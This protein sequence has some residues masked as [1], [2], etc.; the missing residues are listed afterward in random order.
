MSLN[1][2]ARAALMFLILYTIL[3]AFLL[4]GYFTRRLR[5]RSRYTVILFHVTIRLASQ[6]TGFAFG[7]VGY[8][9]TSLLIAYFILGAE[10][11]FTLVL[12]TYRFLISWQTHNFASHD[13]WLEPRYP[14]GTPIFKRLI[15]SFIFVGQRRR[16]MSLMHN[17]LIAAN[18]LIIIGGS[19]MRSGQDSVRGF[20]PNIVTA[21]AMRTAG[22]ATFLTINAF[23]LY[24][25]I[26][27]IR[28]SRRENPGQGTHPTLLLL[29]ATWPLLFVRGLYGVMSGVLPA[30]NYFNPNNYGETG[31]LDSFVISEY[32]MGT[33]MEWTSC[34]L[35]MATYPASRS[36]PQKADLELSKD[37]AARLGGV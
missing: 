36:D 32:I 18:L 5:L 1:A 17:L 16:P 10:G 15:L 28:Q 29:L 2:E 35:L 9:N 23:L 12:C 20:D 25:I 7:V 8:A 37:K 4:F 14:P 13:S 3:L 24:C 30:F 33:A 22:Q 27:T 21:K 6:A 34:V 11:Y 31:L 19:M 26:D